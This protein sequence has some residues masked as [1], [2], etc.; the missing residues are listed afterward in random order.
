[1]TITLVE[2]GAILMSANIETNAPS[3]TN[4]PDKTGE[5]GCGA[6]PCALGNQI[7]SGNAPNLENPAINNNI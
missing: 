3:L 1:M 5:N 4:P 7:L 6:L 2:N